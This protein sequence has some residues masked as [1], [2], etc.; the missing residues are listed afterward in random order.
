MRELASADVETR[1]IKNRIISGI[2]EAA[3]ILRR[4]DGAEYGIIYRALFA[5]GESWQP[6]DFLSVI[7]KSKRISP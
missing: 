6:K 4:A 7:E 1:D 2:R 5:L 3:N